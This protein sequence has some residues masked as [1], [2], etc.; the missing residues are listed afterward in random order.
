MKKYTEG[1]VI[2][3]FYPPHLGHHYLIDTALEQS[4]HVTVLVLGTL[5]DT[6]SVKDRVKMLEAVHEN[7]NITVKPVLDHAYDDYDSKI[8]WKVHQTLM[9]NKL[10]VFPDAVF[11]SETY[12]SELAENFKAEHVCVDY[13][14]H[15]VP[16]SA[17][18]IRKDLYLQWNRMHKEVQKYFRT[19]VVVMGAE[20]TGTTTLAK[21][22]AKHYRKRGG[23]F[24]TTPYIPE[25]GREYS[26]QRVLNGAVHAEGWGTEDFWNIAKG[27]QELY[28]EAVGNTKSP[29]VISDTDGFATEAFGGYYGVPSG[30][31]G[32]SDYSVFSQKNAGSI[33]LITDHENMPMVIDPARLDDIDDRDTSTQS[34]ID[35]CNRYD[36]PYIL[37]SGNRAERLET[38]VKLIDKLMAMKAFIRPPVK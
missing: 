6:I 4:E 22:L 37:M 13:K 10:D 23:I 5:F 21:D 12:G 34:F 29:L 33:Y 16:I 8:I 25:Y 38:S 36:L 15:H 11:T 19:E 26:E 27:Q 32:V 30:E 35:I 3:K 18:A 14:R 9:E 28:L 2:G 1:L 20:S 31:T 24:S 17:T 7:M